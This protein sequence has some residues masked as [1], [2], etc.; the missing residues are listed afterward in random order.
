MPRRLCRELALLAPTAGDGP[1][2]A[3]LAAAAS[4]AVSA[5]LP[6]DRALPSLAAMI[7]EVVRDFDVAVLGADWASEMEQ[8]GHLAALESARV[9]LLQGMLRG[10]LAPAEPMYFTNAMPLT[11]RDAANRAIDGCAILQS[12]LAQMPWRERFAYAPQLEEL[13]AHHRCEAMAATRRA[14]ELRLEHYSPPIEVWA[15]IAQHLSAGDA[16]SFAACASWTRDLVAPR[17]R[18][19][20]VRGEALQRPLAL[21][22][23]P[24]RYRSV[25]RVVFD[26]K[27]RAPPPAA[28]AAI[29]D[30]VRACRTPSVR[31]FVSGTLELDAG[32]WPRAPVHN[33]TLTA[34]RESARRSGA[35]DVCAKLGAVFDLAA[36]HTLRLRGDSY[37]NFTPLSLFETCALD[38][39]CIDARNLNM[40]VGVP[41]PLLRRIR[42]LR[43]RD[44]DGRFSSPLSAVQRAA[45]FAPQQLWCETAA[46]AA[47]A[48]DVLV[49]SNH[50]GTTGTDADGVSTGFLLSR[51]H[52]GR[53][54]PVRVRC[55][56][57]LDEA[58]HNYYLMEANEVDVANDAWFAHHFASLPLHVAE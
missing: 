23:P 37:A 50:L 54:A 30:V 34:T 41:L 10:Q 43:L 15:I 46:D 13:R 8:A 42:V 14:L 44:R 1:K 40:L 3:A 55:E 47:V 38:T 35:R 48:I 5:A 57:Q 17:W 11:A 25:T 2:F 19:M 27:R 6:V 39:V 36:L 51:I 12:R 20:I 53:R 45:L 29:A 56:T 32:D 33:L 26:F 28:A 49:H 7:V 52:Y 58:Q 9:A 16:R 31:L 22:L 4:S 18:R 24:D 21:V